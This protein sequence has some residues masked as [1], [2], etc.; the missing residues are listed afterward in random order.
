MLLRVDLKAGHG[1]GKPA[2]KQIEEYTDELSFFVKYH[3]M[4]VSSSFFRKI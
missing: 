2:V 3:N 1:G 4:N